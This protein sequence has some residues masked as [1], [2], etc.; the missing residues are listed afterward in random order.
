MLPFRNWT[1]NFLSKVKLNWSYGTYTG[2]QRPLLFPM[3]PASQKEL[4]IP[5]LD[6]Y[7]GGIKCIFAC[8][9]E[10]ARELQSV[11]EI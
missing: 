9:C 7:L 4:P 10:R 6:N 3:W 11:S 1:V 8:V 2:P 5:G